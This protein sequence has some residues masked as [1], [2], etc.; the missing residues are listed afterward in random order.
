MPLARFDLGGIAK[1][2]AVDC[3]ID[4]MLPLMGGEGAQLALVNA[5]GDMRHAGIE[6]VQV[7]LREPGRRRALRGC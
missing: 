3:A 5:G 4:A 7:A 2:Y 6:P 1:G